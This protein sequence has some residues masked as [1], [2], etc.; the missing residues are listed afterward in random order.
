[1]R[2]F[3]AGATGAVGRRLVPLLVSNGHEV[4]GLT[5]TPEKAEAVRALGAQA[6]IADGLNAHSIRSAVVSARPDIIVH[7]MTDLRG[8]SDLRAFDRSFATSN[9]LRTEGV[10]HL[11]S[12]ARE[13]GVKRLVAQSFC[14]WPYA[15]TGGPVKSED[16]PL[17]P[18]PPKEFRRTLDAIRYL[19]AAVVGAD[20][21]EGVVLRY[22]AFYGEGSGVFDGSMVGELRRRRVPLIGDAAGWW[23]FLHVDDAARATAVAVE[24]NCTGIYNI[25]DDDPA[26]VSTWLPALAG[27]LKAKRPFRASVWL[28]RLIAGEHVVALMTQARAGSNAKAKKELGWRP[29]Y[30]SWR[31]GFME[32]A[33]R[34]PG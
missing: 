16:D 28:A 5:R 25:V 29:V 18:D 8:A 6:V 26:P 14:G 15:R 10:D 2:I 9:R 3:V 34:L 33:A 21:L 17:D 11:L 20:H 22:G 30:S 1:M 7:E 24:G 31:E 4:V 13:A 27:L 19:E 32:V 12:A 23:S